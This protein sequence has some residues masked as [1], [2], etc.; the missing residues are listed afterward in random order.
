MTDI[1]WLIEVWVAKQKESKYPMMGGHFGSD[2]EAALAYIDAL[3]PG[4]QYTINLSGGWQ[5]YEISRKELEEFGG[6]EE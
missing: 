2:K 5:V 4:I 3:E 1:G 6:K